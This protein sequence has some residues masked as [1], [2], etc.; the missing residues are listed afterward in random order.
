MRPVQPM[1]LPLQIHP[2]PPRILPPPASKKSL[3]PHDDIEQYPIPYIAVKNNK[4]THPKYN[5]HKY[6]LTTWQ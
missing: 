6:L 1:R 3:Q 5:S 2:L 4:K